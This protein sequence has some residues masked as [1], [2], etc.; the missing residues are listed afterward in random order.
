MTIIFLKHHNTK[1]IYKNIIVIFFLVQKSNS[2]LTSL[3]VSNL[4]QKPS[5]NK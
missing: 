4:E 5:K 2:S 3:F 1:R